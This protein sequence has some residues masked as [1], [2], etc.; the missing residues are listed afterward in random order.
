MDNII[1]KTTTFRDHPG[2]KVFLEEMQDGKKH[3]RKLHK[4]IDEEWN[5][6]CF[7]HKTGINVPELYKKD[8]NGM[9]MQY[10]DGGMLWDNY[11]TADMET[12]QDLIIKYY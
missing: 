1:E 10:I 8:K 6:L 7:L 4:N 2:Y 9:Y 11:Q 3:I 12:K 5:T